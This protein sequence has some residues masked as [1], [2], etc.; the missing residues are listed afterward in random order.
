MADRRVEIAPSILSADLARLGEQVREAE[1]AGA[2]AIH[3]DVM[4][5][6]FVPRITFGP[7]VVAAVRSVTSL[8]LDVHLMIEAPERQIEEFVAAGAS[9]VI[10][11]VES[12]QLLGEVVR[13]IRAGGARVAVTLKP[14]TAL[15]ALDAVLPEIDQVQVMSVNPGWS[16]QSFMPESLE[17]LEAV[18]TSLARLG[19]DAVLEVD[20]GVNEETVASVVAAGA[21]LI[22]AGSAV[23]N[24][25]ESVA[26]S[27]GRLRS[28]I[29]AG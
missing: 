22:V 18:R 16:G 4:D 2:D 25:R 17:R 28:A 27:M 24:G 7:V 15:S 13:Q 9:T 21:N 1:A 3:I 20:G 6:V 26:V 5:G 8:P 11:H 12:T 29:E 14:D 23:F 10:V 19:I